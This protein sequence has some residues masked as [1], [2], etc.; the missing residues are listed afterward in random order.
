MRSSMIWSPGI[1]L[2]DVVLVS[3]F[4]EMSVGNDH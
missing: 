4:L 1:D 3:T 2:A